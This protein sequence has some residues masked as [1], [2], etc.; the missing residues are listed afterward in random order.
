[1]RLY[2]L[3]RFG[4]KKNLKKYGSWAVVTGSTDGIGKAI[5][6]QLAKRGINIVLISRSED[7]LNAVAEELGKFNV[8]IKTV[9]YDFNNIDGY[10]EI[11]KELE[12]LE[13]GILVNNVGISYGH[14]DYFLEQSN[15]FCD[16]L[17]NVN[18]TSMHKMTKMV[19]EGMVKRKR[20]LVVNLSSLA[21]LIPV[22][23]LSLYSGSKAFVTF[24]SKALNG[25]YSR[26]GVHTMVLSPFYVATNL[27][28]VRARG[29]NI[30][31]ADRYAAS[32]VN[33]FG[34]T[35]ATC[36][37]WAHDIHA[38]AQALLPECFLFDIV[39]GKME[40]ARK[41]WYR[42]QEQKKD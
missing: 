27:S 18:V 24:F 32:A 33:T 6:K 9:T 40:H 14:P 26:S 13:I 5:A 23:L 34:L 41:R 28:Q 21:G 3:P 10:E 37:W 19:I 31:S 42:K 20:G 16:R 35:T 11:G 2:F 1:M 8:S 4:M 7:K 39:R 22:P 15:E 25:E 30:P 38:F 17:I 29:M 36:G 12:D